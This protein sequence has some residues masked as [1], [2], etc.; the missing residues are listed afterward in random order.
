F[1][2]RHYNRTMTFRSGICYTRHPMRRSAVL[3][4][5]ASLSFTACAIIP[6]SMPSPKPSPPAAATAKR[7]QVLMG[8]MVEI[9]AVAPNEI[10]AQAALTAGFHEIRR[11]EALISTWIETSDLSRVNRAAGVEPVG[12]SDETF[13]LLTKAL[14]V[15]DYTEGGFN[16]AIGPGVRLW[17]IP[18]APRI[19]SGMELEIA[20]QYVDYRRIHLDASSRSVFLEKPGMRIDVGGIGKGFAAEKAAAVMREVGAS[21]GV[22]AVSGDLRIFGKQ[23]DGTR[24]PIY[25]EHPRQPGK[26]LAVL[27]TTDEAISTAGDYKRFFI[28]DGVRYHHILDPRTLQPA[29]LCQSVTVVAPD[30]TLADGL[31]TGVFVM[32]P[33][34]G[35]ALIER[36]GFGAV[37]VDAE[38]VVTVSSTLRN[39]V[40]LNP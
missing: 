9:T 16:I 35:M 31:D 30:G 29:R 34:K 27:E 17:N 15:A 33:M 26:F 39:R 5:L 12:V 6:V 2:A 36:L 20:A 37:I 4:L 32:G 1:I 14:E 19:P 8:T 40:R 10:L 13:Y 24:W 11:I 18:E 21:G 23:A 38:G 22:V 25:I 28:K 3:F 7:A